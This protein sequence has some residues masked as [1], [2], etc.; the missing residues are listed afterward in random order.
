MSSET[1]HDLRH[2]TSAEIEANAARMRTDIAAAQRIEQL[3]DEL[4][5]A[6]AENEVYRG[7]FGE[8]KP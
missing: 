6:R 7:R 1:Y 2:V 5:K 3:E 4:Q 8:L